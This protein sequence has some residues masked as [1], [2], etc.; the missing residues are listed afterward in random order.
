MVAETSNILK[1]LEVLSFC[2]RDTEGLTSFDKDNSANFSGEKN[3]SESFRDIY[4][5]AG[6]NLKPKLVLV[7]SRSRLKI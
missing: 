2:D 5:W 4:F 6:K 7:R 3:Y 1:M